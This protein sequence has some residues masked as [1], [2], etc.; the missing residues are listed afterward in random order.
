MAMSYNNISKSKEKNQSDFM[1]ISITRVISKR[2]AVK[3]QL[4]SM[5]LFNSDYSI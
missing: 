4:M 2:V 1:I 3:I 5:Y